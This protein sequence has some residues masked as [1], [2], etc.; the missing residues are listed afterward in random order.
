[1]NHPGSFDPAHDV[2]S[3]Q[4]EYQDPLHGE[5]AVL[6]QISG[7]V[8]PG[9]LLSL[10]PGYASNNPSYVS[11]T[12]P[13]TCLPPGHYRV[14]LFV[15]G[16][17]AGDNH[18]LQRLVGPV[19]RQVQRGGRRNGRPGGLEAVSQPG[20]WCGRLRCAQQQRRGVHPEHPQ[21]RRGG[22]CQ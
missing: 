18:R 17:L 3:A 19:R 13:A 7:P 14:Q 6:P 12:S 20:G 2:L 22:D 11:N 16:H 9:G 10:S 1:M 8:T 5:W 4:W 21:G 15:N